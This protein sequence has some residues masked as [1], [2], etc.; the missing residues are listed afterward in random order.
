MTDPAG[1]TLLHQEVEHTIIK[2]SSFESIHTT[3]TYTMQQIVVDII[4]LQVFHGTF[5]HLL[6][7][8]KRP[9]TWIRVRHLGSNVILVT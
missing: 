2:E 7:F 8:L 5:I 3:A 9:G 1:L 6:R 4:H